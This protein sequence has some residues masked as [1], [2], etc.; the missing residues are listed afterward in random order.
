MSTFAGNN[1]QNKLVDGQGILAQ[2]QSP[3]GL[4]VNSLGDVFV[5][6]TAN[7]AVRKISSNGAQPTLKFMFVMFKLFSFSRND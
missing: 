3:Q 6:D 1:N 4:C 2:F 7:D 5:A